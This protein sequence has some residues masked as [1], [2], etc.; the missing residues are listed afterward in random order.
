MSSKPTEVILAGRWTVGIIKSSNHV[1][2]GFEF[3]DQPAINLALTREQ[4]ADIAAALQAQVQSP[5][6]EQ[7]N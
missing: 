5:P 4:A 1:V 3:S 2:L 6:P 7:L